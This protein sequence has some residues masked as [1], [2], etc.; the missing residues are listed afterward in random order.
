MPRNRRCALAC[1]MR[2]ASWRRFFAKTATSDSLPPP[3]SPVLQSTRC[4]METEIGPK[5][6]NAFEATLPDDR[7]ILDR[8]DPARL[9]APPVVALRRWA[10]VGAGALLAAAGVLLAWSLRVER[11][12]AIEPSLE[13]DLQARSSSRP[14]EEQ[15]GDAE[16]ITPGAAPERMGPDRRET[17]RENTALAPKPSDES[18]GTDG[19]A[20]TSSMGGVA[21]PAES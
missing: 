6:R 8:Y 15:R 17:A 11:P 5:M 16:R 14:K 13:R 2:A 20:E 3:K 21:T 7:A 1:A 10:G 18:T 4:P 9:K 12:I 19:Q